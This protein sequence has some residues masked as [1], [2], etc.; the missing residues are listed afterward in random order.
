MSPMAVAEL[1]PQS[2]SKC[3]YQSVKGRS[4]TAEE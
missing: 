3:I 1:D 4:H 2:S